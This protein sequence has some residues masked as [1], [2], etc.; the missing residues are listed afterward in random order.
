M[1]LRWSENVFVFNRDNEPG[2]VTFN[3][4]ITIERSKWTT[5]KSDE[6][7]FPLILEVPASRFVFLSFIFGV[8]R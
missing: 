6:A 2:E 7:K 1:F 5:K 3:L 8:C 4:K